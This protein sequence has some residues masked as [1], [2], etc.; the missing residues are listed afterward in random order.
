M[1]SLEAHKHNLYL[2]FS[3][4][5]PAYAEVAAFLISQPKSEDRSLLKLGLHRDTFA[6]Q[7]HLIIPSGLR[8]KLRTTFVGKSSI[9]RYISREF[10]KGGGRLYEQHALDKQAHIDSFLDSVRL[11][12]SKNVSNPKQAIAPMENLVKSLGRDAKSLTL[13]ELVAWDFAKKHAGASTDVDKWVS[14]L[15]KVVELKEAVQLV[16]D[17]LSKA[18]ILDEYRYTISVQLAEITGQPLSVIFPLLE[19]KI[20]RDATG[21]DYFVLDKKI[22]ASVEASGIFLRFTVNREYFRDTLLPRVLKHSSKYGWNASGYGKV[23]VVEFSSPNIAKPFHVGHLR[24]TIIGNFVQKTLDANGWATVS[25]NYLGD[26]GKQYGLLAI[27]FKKYGSEEELAKDPIRHLYEVYVKI[28]VDAGEDD[29]VNDQARDYFGAM[30]AG[31]KEAIELWQRFRDLSIVKYTEVYKRVNVAFE[32]YSGESMYSAKQMRSVVDRLLG[33]GLLVPDNGA[34][35]V[36]LN[37]YKLGVAIIEKRDGGGMLY[38]S[39]DIAAAIDRQE[40]YQFDNM[41][42]CVGMQQE[43]HFKKLFKILELMG[44]PWADRCKHISFG[45]IKTKDGQMSTR[46]GTVLFLEDILNGVQESMLEVMKK[47][48][49]KYKQIEDPIGVSDLV[50]ITAIMVQDM[51]ARRSKDYEFDWDRMLAFEGDT[52]PYLQYAHA[53]LCSIERNAAERSINASTTTDL[54]PLT[55]DPAM[56]L[57]DLISLYPDIVRD[58]AISLEPCN[59][60]SYSFKL[61]HGVMVAL[62]HLYVLNQ[63]KHI[64]EARLVM[65]KAARIT[66]GNALSSL[67][68]IPLERM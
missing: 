54:T 14:D 1:S 40:T 53:R 55:E 6:D 65:Y 35:I 20:P 47:N 18:H 7:A 29:S 64:A 9:I 36:D 12:S 42:Y 22:L 8:T 28:N 58:A 24:S 57:L 23:A 41:F 62:E 34:Q 52:G 10:A 33:L 31:N 32:V 2:T 68:L 16:N 67:G 11:A 3:P 66:L 49:A 56:A 46:K 50:G 37:K 44:L 26:W 48:E 63:P 43:D 51:S 19:S 30:E 25:I 27:G 59:I 4:A 5:C 61:A 39:R 21:A 60:V 13:A 17:T 38:I 45:M 15:E